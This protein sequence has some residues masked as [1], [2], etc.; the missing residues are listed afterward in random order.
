MNFLELEQTIW[1]DAYKERI[2]REEQNMKS[3]YEL[4]K[5]SITSA[6]AQ[7][8]AN[9]SRLMNHLSPPQSNMSIGGSVS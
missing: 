9:F 6:V 8:G 1:Y 5:S 4:V 3:D 2:A 7:M